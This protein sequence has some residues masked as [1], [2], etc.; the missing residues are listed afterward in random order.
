MIA[1]ALER[2]VRSQL[3]AVDRDTF[4]FR[5]MLTREAVAAA[6]LPPRRATL[7]AQALARW[8]PPIPGCRADT[9]TSP[10]TWPCRPGER[11]GPARC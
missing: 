9:A 6:L 11:A 8:R 10:R 2:G 5:H 1:G 3:L 4:R 7:A